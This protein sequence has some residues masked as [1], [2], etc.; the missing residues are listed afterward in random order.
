MYKLDLKK[1]CSYVLFL[2]VFWVAAAVMPSSVWGAG[3]LTTDNSEFCMV[4]DASSTCTALSENMSGCVTDSN[5]ICTIVNPSGP[6]I[7]VQVTPL[8]A[9]GSVPDPTLGEISWQ[10]LP[11]GPPLLTGKEIDI[12]ILLGATG[13]GTSAWIYSP[14]ANSDMGLAFEKNNGSYQKVNGIFFCSDF[15]APPPSVPKLV[16]KKTV[17]LKGGT[18][19]TDLVPGDDVENLSLKVGME[20]QYCFFVE[21]I[22]IGDATNVTLSDPGVLTQ[23]IGNLAASESTL[24]TSDPVTISSQGETVNSANVT[25]DS[26]TGVAVPKATDSATVNAQLALE[27]CP[28]DYQAAVDG[29]IFEEDFF[30]YA[31]LLDPL[32]PDRLSICVPSNVDSNVSCINQCILKDDCKDPSSQ[33]YDA[34]EC[35]APTG[36]KCEE[37]GNWA[38]LDGNGV[39][40]LPNG[41]A[42]Y[43]WEAI[44]DRDFNCAY[45]AVEPLQSL[46]I[47]IEQYHDNPFCYLSC[48]DISDLKTCNYICF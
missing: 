24:I 21:N 31:A 3:C 15:L 40:Q 1:R 17:M 23:V 30:K 46:D 44:Q 34:L 28:D 41:E 42:P 25:G 6:N 19:G 29:Q 35:E 5:G 9:V 7:V 45:K 2:G 4:V 36:S 47:N 26:F 20:V 18:C 22:G 11:G 14:G 12:G 38:K 37:S 39:C 27:L 10:V 13:G 32:D 43:C 16:L 48:A 8:D 33:N